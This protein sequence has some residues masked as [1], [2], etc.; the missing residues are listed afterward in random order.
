MYKNDFFL[1]VSQLTSE[2]CGI[3]FLFL[4]TELHNSHVD[5]WKR[6]CIK[7]RVASFGGQFIGRIAGTPGWQGR[8]KKDRGV[9]F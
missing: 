4:L 2:F 1:P 8:V 9:S 5:K 6:G 7:N 3:I